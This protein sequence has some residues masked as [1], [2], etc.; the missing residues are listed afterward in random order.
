MPIIEELMNHSN[1]FLALAAAAIS[2]V[3]F[4]SCGGVS[5]SDVASID[6]TTISKT[7]FD[8]WVTVAASASQDPAAKGAGAPDPPNYVKCIAAKK[9]AAPEPVK[10]QPD[11][12]DAEFK[13][14]CADQFT[15]LKDQVM[16]FLI[17]STWLELQAN[18]AGIE[19]SDAK[20][21]AEFDKARKQA[22]PT[23]KQYSDF[24]KSS[25]QTEADLLFRQRSQM[26]EKAITDQVQKA[27]K[28]VTPDEISAYYKKN[29]A[30]FTQPATRDLNVILTKTEAEANKAKAALEGGES[31]A[32]VA[33]QYSIDSTSKKDGGKLPAVAQG[34]QEGA[35][36]K[37]IFSAP[38]DKVAGPVKTSLGYYVFEVTK[39]TP[40]KIQTE[41]QAQKAI[42]Q[43]VISEKAQTSLAAFGKSYQTRWKELTD[44]QTGY[45]VAD[46]NNYKAPKTPAATPGQPAAPTA[47]P[48][49]G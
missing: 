26:L 43:I 25:G 22:F 40:K 30:Q 6:G 36:D 32:S 28:T 23:A 4:A 44:C 39:D 45:I 9:A 47:P 29:Q 27:S 31:F 37:A 34:S 16:T 13:K 49:G 7:T 12:T 17:R 38:L 8:R 1:R 11:P 41:A 21:K 33:N 19:I 15:Q 2:A 24:L 14:Q 42:K 20:V 10:G 46:C 35:F 3:A 5:D 18:E 48:S